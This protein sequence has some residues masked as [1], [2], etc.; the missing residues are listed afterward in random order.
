MHLSSWIVAILLI[1]GG[2]VVL[3]H[4][5]VDIGTLVAN[6]A[7]SVEHVLGQPL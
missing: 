5:G 7:H 4:L 6:A 1:V 2:A 3:N